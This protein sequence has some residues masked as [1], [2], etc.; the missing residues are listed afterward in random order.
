MRRRITLA[1]LG[2]VAAALLLAG[3]GTLALTRV[4]ARS[5]ARSELEA[6]AQATSLI[7]TLRTNATRDTDGTRL[8]P[9]ERLTRIRD[10]LNLE[11]VSLV[12]IDSK[13]ENTSAMVLVH[14]KGRNM[15]P[16]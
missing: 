13:D 7:A 11:D 9:K 10:S 14:A 16:S 8:T 12:V 6:Q 5:S 1:I 3:L 4:G 15:R 2:T